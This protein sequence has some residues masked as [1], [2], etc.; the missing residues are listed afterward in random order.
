[1]TCS[2]VCLTKSAYVKPRF[3]FIASVGNEQIVSHC[4]SKWH[5]LLEKILP[6]T[7]NQYDYS[8]LVQIYEYFGRSTR[9]QFP[10]QES[11]IDDFTLYTLDWNCNLLSFQSF[12]SFRTDFQYL[13]PC[14][15]NLF[16]KVFTT[17]LYTKLLWRLQNT[18]M[19]IDCTKKFYM[20]SEQV[21]KRPQGINP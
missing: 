3:Y 19:R 11:Q 7:T 4:T 16:Y 13:M 1:M 6:Q 17:Q 12:G 18:V 15:F 8:N 21:G 14:F 5:L 10:F 2:E 20:I 9:Q